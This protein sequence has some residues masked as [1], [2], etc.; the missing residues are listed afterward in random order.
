MQYSEDTNLKAGCLETTISVK[1]SAAE[2]QYLENLTERD[3]S[4]R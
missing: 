2:I 3:C 4:K 1:I